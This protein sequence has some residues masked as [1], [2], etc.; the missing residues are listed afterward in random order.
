MS[1]TPPYQ[2]FN[3]YVT[4][5]LP[6]AVD[7]LF[8]SSASVSADP[9]PVDLTGYTPIDVAV[10]PA[11][12]EERP[13]TSEES[14]LTLTATLANQSGGEQGR[15]QLRASAAD[16]ALLSDGVIERGRC[17]VLISTSGEHA[18]VWD[19]GYIVVADPISS[20]PSGVGSPVYTPAVIERSLID[21]PSGSIPNSAAITVDFTQT[22]TTDIYTSASSNEKP[23]RA[24]ILLTSVTDFVDVPTVYFKR[25]SDNQRFNADL[26]LTGMNTAGEFRNIFF[27]G[28][29]PS[30]DSGEKIQIVVETAADAT[31]Y[32][33]T[34]S[35]TIDS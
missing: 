24:S 14:V 22:G 16:T 27:S 13:A 29:V 6:V 23:V 5:G 12:D 4:P 34:V 9:L 17:D 11:R 7:L 35:T 28:T 26:K 1:V 8:L 2:P 21:G 19:H 15:L 32:T 10:K 18:E 3:L 30:I 25:S 20:A 31:V 33:G